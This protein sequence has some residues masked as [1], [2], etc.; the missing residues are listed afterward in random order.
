MGSLVVVPEQVVDQFL[1]ESDDVP[2]EELKMVLD[3]LL[4]K[5]AIESLDRT[6]HLRTARVRVIVADR[7]L[8]ARVMEEVRELAPVV[9]L[10]L[11]DRERRHGDQFS[12]EVGSGCRRMVR[13][14][15]R[16]GEAS[17]DV[18]CREDVSL[19]RADEPNDRI[20][21][22]TAFL[23]FGTAD[24]WLYSADSFVHAAGACVHPHRFVPWKQPAFLEIRKHSANVW[25]GDREPFTLEYRREF[26]LAETVMLRSQ[27]NDAL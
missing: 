11:R 20:D 2:L 22:H 23:L 24:L 12:Q 18:D 8:P 5:R 27:C 3:E 14:C 21:L 10:Y 7:E 6:V 4:R 16:E 17:L 19:R 15:G 9:G 25:L 26:S 13:I 1:V